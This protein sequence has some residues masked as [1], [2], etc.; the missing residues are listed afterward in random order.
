MLDVFFTSV[1]GYAVSLAKNLIIALIVFFIGKK[2][3]KLVLKFLNNAM[4]KAHVEP[5][6]VKFVHS[7]AKFSLYAVLAVAV[8][9][10]LGVPTTT[11]V[12]LLGTVS[13]T[14]GLAL[15]GSLSNFAGGVLIMLFK[16]FHVG[17]YIVACGQ[18]GTVTGI[19]VFYTKLATID[20]K[21]IVIPNGT[22]ANSSLVNVS[23]EKE[24][25]LDLTVGISYNSDIEKAKA[26]LTEILEKTPEVIP[27]KEITVYVSSL[28]ASQVTIGTRI[29]VKGEDYWT[30]RWRLLEQYKLELDANGIEIPFN[31]LSVTMR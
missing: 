5:M 23:A 24:R 9:S 13:L 14:V 2:L 10:I 18:E 11:F 20:N 3:V 19:D 21:V 8:V 12:T 28:D 22:L 27:G 31:Q 6:V 1:T 7:I 16:P 26:V 29:W 15:Q 17:D 30:T 25:R 4:G